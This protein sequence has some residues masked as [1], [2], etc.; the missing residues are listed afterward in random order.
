VPPISLGH[1]PNAWPF[2]A[3]GVILSSSINV[4]LV[5]QTHWL[6]HRPPPPLI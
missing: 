3:T 2:S 5:D 4:E 1:L 6:V